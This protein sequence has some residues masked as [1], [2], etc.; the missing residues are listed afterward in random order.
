MLVRIL[1]DV[2]AHA[3]VCVCVCVCVCM[4]LYICRDQRT[5]CKSQFWF[6]A[7]TVWVLG[8]EL[9]TSDLVASTFS[10]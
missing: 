6:S 3:S 7:S 2:F 8:I 9:R 5:T 4:A 10:C 1:W